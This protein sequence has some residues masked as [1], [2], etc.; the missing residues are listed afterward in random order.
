MNHFA[1]T[2]QLWQ[3]PG[4]PTS[5]PPT[6]HDQT[7]TYNPIAYGPMPGHRLSPKAAG[8]T[9]KPAGGSNVDHHG[10]TQGEALAQ[11]E[12]PP[13]P[14]SGHFLYRKFPSMGVNTNHCVHSTAETLGFSY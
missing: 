1:G 14:V 2:E 12:K 10:S 13:L 3:L 5:A 11:A 9:A 7:P 8:D 6:S 4:P